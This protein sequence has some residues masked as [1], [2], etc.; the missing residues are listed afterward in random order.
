MQ[1][2]CVVLGV[3]DCFLG[4]LLLCLALAHL[5]SSSILDGL[6]GIEVSSCVCNGRLLLSAGALSE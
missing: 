2:T 1:P 6:Q 4:C 5:F 3:E